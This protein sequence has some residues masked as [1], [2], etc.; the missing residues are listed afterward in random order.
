MAGMAAVGLFFGIEPARRADRDS[1]ELIEAGGAGLS[2]V[3][4][5]VELQ[6][7]GCGRKVR[8][9]KALPSP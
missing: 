8:R 5:L 7:D 1:L 4:Q 9:S 6:G 2:I 3:K